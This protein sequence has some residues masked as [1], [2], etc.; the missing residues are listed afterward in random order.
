MGAP[1]RQSEASNAKTVVKRAK[2]PFVFFAAKHKA[3]IRK[4]EGI[5]GSREARKLLDKAVI[6]RWQALTDEER[7]PYLKLAAEDR[8]RF[9]SEIADQ[10]SEA[11][12]SKGSGKG[13]ALPKVARGPY[14]L[15]CQE[16]RR[17]LPAG[18]SFKDSGRM[19]SEQFKT[20]TPEQKERYTQMANINKKSLQALKTAQGNGTPEKKVPEKRACSGYQLYT[21]DFA[22]RP[23]CKLLKGKEWMKLAAAAWKELSAEDRAPYMERSKV[24]RAEA[25]EKASASK[26]KKGGLRKSGKAGVKKF[27]AKKA[28]KGEKL[29][30]ETPKISGDVKETI[31][32]S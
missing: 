17:N 19:L 26:T 20:L 21:K 13:A 8:E 10:G 25:S 11:V 18:I 29:A 27:S 7:A 9:R 15:F 23:E 4:E 6:R 32:R 12:V 31:E 2:K 30:C 3:T 28:T 1:T 5:A 16:Q 14:I 22:A 24:M